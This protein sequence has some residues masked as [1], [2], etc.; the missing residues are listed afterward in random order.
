M[1][2]HTVN[3]I[4]A[5]PFF[6]NSN[7]LVRQRTN[8]L[9]ANAVNDPVTTVITV[10][11][12]AGCGKTQAVLDFLKQQGG[13]FFW[14]QISE[15][16]N[17]VSRLWEN[18]VAS[19]N[20]IDSDMAVQCS[21]I[22]FPDT[23]EKI[24]KF[25]KFR[26]DTL[27]NNPH[28]IVWD[29]VHLLKEPS[30]LHFAKII[31]N[32]LSPNRK[33]ILIGRDLPEINFKVLDLKGYVSHIREKNLNFTE[34]ELTDYFKKLKLA[35]DS[36]TIHEIYGDTK[37]WVFAINLIARSLERLPK[38]FGYIQ[39]TFKK[40]IFELME[41]ESW[42]LLSGQ[43][44]RFLV[45]LS[46]IDHL[47]AELV[48][49]LAAEETHV[50]SE[51]K[52][53]NTYIRFDDSL[54]TYLIHHLFL[55]FLNTK[56]TILTEDD[57]YKTYKAAADWCSQ[58]N[59]KI[60]ALN[61]YEKI[62][63]YESI[64]SM[65]F[66]LPLDIPYEI[67]QFA[68][69]IFDRAPAE[70]FDRV[71][72]FATTHVN[73]VAML[74]N[75][76]EFYAL[77]DYYERRFLS[78]PEDDEM[79]SISLCGI[80]L[81]MGIMRAACAHDDV[82]DF[83]IYFAKMFDNMTEKFYNSSPPLDCPRGPW[84]NLTYSSKKGEP[85]KYIE[86][87]IRSDET[88]ARYS[89]GIT[90]GAD[91]LIQGELLFYQG[92]VKAAEPF[93]VNAIESAIKRMAFETMHR[94]LFYLL[95]IAVAEGNT[96]KAETVLRDTEN[97]LNEKLYFKRYL[98][99]DISLGWF[100]YILRRPEMFPEWL[101]EKFSPYAHTS[102]IQNF[103]NQ[104]KARYYFLTK[105]YLPLLSYIR[106]MKNRESFLFGRIEMLAMEACVYYKMKIKNKAWDSFKEA[107]ETAIPNDIQMPFIELGKDMR[108]LII[109]ALREHP[110]DTALSIGI[111]RPWLESIKHK[112]ISYSKSQS[113]FINAYQ[114][115]DSDVKTLTPR[116]KDVLTY[117]YNGFSQPEI[118]NK[119]EL[120][121]NTIKMITKILYDKLNVH[122]ISDL[123][124]IAAEQKFL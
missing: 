111:P 11:A 117:L 104:I 6:I 12:G 32:V 50:L 8:E 19:I 72:Y 119:L 5:N 86:A 62:N 100:Q 42:T 65:F 53:V 75:M 33:M 103:G 10:C 58:N 31:I 18:I 16:D 30:V 60:D 71:K 77:F 92:K 124:R 101:T 20:R 66:F 80:Y 4:A 17:T 28:I 116:E 73:I 7:H 108:S 36:H 81:S 23:D 76:Q 47:S 59:F 2:S 67:A 98:T 61:Y 99:Y 39:N 44:K 14:V 115:N 85:Q 37:G 90:M 69:G 83:D 43:L 15:R 55:H 88:T 49:I 123:I 64:V 93:V 112:T 91:L 27:T 1:N 105:N 54:G 26:N 114:K 22:G 102:G 52:N 21:E 110:G 107:Y 41:A 106:E 25:A 56:H 84:L 120:S 35:V 78:L 9:L 3:G 113:L 63:D 48:E 94:A 89:K 79:R 38:Y 118:A 70:T 74:G 46:L 51:L 34:N 87:T 109:A 24:E 122:K 29:D 57:K 45:R 68:K 13:L 97:L 95:R 40:D 121:V 82:Y 96:K